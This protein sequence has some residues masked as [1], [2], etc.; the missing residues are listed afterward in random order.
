MPN[1]DQTAPGG[2]S[3]AAGLM[4]P[5]FLAALADAIAAV[6]PPSPPV[7]TGTTPAAVPPPAAPVSLPTRI[8]DAAGQAL[9]PLAA[10][11]LVKA[12]S[13][14]KCPSLWVVVGTIAGLF[15]QNP[16]GLQLHPATQVAAAAVAAI[17][18]AA[19]AIVDNGNTGGGNG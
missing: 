13:K 15:A 7:E 12:A 2:S 16:L 6:L 10:P 18:V 5:Q 4:T 14:F 11:I 17:Y 3:A 19:Q 9:A 1:G 8:G